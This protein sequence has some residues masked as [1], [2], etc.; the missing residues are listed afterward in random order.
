MRR[1]RVVSVLLVLSCA[2]ADDTVHG[3]AQVVQWDSA[4]RVVELCETGL[5]YQ[6]GVFT[7][8]A[9]GAGAV[10]VEQWLSAEPGPLLVEIVAHPAELPSSWPALPGVSGVLDVGSIWPLAHKTCS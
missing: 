3:R 6:L 2:S 7:S 4:A 10:D 8:N 5:R 9:E 1:I